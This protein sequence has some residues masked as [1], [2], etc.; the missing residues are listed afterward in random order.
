M[1][2][3]LESLVNKNLREEKSLLFGSDSHIKI[4]NIKWSTHEKRYVITTKIYVNEI[5]KSTEAYPEG[6]NFL[7]TEGLKFIGLEK[8]PIIINSIDVLDKKN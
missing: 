8:E 5:E 2:K 3:M 1:K 6:V 4:E 7:I